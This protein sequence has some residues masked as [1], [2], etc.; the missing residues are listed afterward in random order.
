M[1]AGL[2]FDHHELYVSPFLLSIGFS[3][4]L[5]A[6]GLNH[7]PARI[8]SKDG[9][10]LCTYVHI[11]YVDRVGTVMIHVSGDLLRTQA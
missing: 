2:I 8:G 9:G 11:Y 6:T 3:L 4:S 10:M 1:S 7:Y 5:S